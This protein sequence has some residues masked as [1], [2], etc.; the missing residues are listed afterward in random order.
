MRSEKGEKSSGNVVG[1]GWGAVESKRRGGK[2]RE[3]EGEG[4]TGNVYKL[5][6]I[7]HI[8]LQLF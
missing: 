8:I 2:E 5:G 1:G 6:S 4:R 3:R 7:L